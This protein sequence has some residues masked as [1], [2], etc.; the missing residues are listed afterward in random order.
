MGEDSGLRGCE[1]ESLHQILD[2]HF[3]IN[4]LNC[5]FGKTESKQK[6]GQ[7]WS[8]FSTLVCPYFGIKSGT[9]LSKVAQKHLAT[10][11]FTQKLPFFNTIQEVAKYLGLFGKNKCC[12]DI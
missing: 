5:L 2:G 9:V 8:I 12:P 4:F 11:D 6:R 3:H 1:F 10:V 7:G